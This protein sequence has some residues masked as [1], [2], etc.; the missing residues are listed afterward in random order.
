MSRRNALEVQ[1]ARAF[2]LKNYPRAIARLN[3]LLTLVGE[4]PHTLYLLALC[5]SRQNDDLEALGF[6]RRALEADA[7]HLEGLKLL[8]RMHFLRGEHP[9]ARD[10]VARALRLHRDGAREVEAP[11]SWL[12]ALTARLGRSS[13]SAPLDA[14]EHRQW[15]IWAESFMASPPDT[16]GDSS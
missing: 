16:G 7:G 13:G 9:Q 15:L 11:R 4:N 1:A 14:R 2:A 10:C 6:A 3:D 12:S 5:H 8:G